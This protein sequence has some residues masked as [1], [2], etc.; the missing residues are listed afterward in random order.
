MKEKIRTF[1]TGAKRD[2]EDGKL[3]YEGFLSP[4]VLQK[5]AE[6]MHTHRWMKDGTYRESD[7]WAKGIPKDVYMKSGLRH[8]MDWWLE[9]RD[10]K[11]RDGIIEALCG[12]LFNAQGYLYEIIKE[13]ESRKTGKDKKKSK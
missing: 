11:S 4:I 3:D 12:L 1:K 2:K 10:F 5:Y 13:D 9:H 8:A 7:D 6:Y